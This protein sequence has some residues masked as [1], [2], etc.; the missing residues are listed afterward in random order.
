MDDNKKDIY[1]NIKNINDLVLVLQDHLEHYGNIPVYINISAG[2]NEGTF[3]VDAVLYG[4]DE[5]GNKFVS[6]IAW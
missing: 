6:L 1:L 2:D 4:T 3:D 5:D